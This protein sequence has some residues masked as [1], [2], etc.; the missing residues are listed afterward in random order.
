MR[1]RKKRREGE[2]RSPSISPN[3][4]VKGTGTGHDRAE[5]KESST[6]CC[7]PFKIKMPAGAGPGRRKKKGKR[8]R[9][10]IYYLS[11]AINKGETRM[12]SRGKKTRG[13][14]CILLVPTDDR[15]E[16]ASRERL[17]FPTQQ[18]GRKGEKRRRK[19][20]LSVSHLDRKEGPAEPMARLLFAKRGGRRESPV[21]SFFVFLGFSSSEIE[22]GASRGGN[23]RLSRSWRAPQGRKEKRGEM[24]EEL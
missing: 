19:S 16:G 1:K 2:A 4:K 22:K 9:G 18:R 6:M 21:D 11:R 24:N 17:F 5:G 23:S 3:E 8:E 15:R 20:A 10:S 12:A 7:I 13:R 14:R